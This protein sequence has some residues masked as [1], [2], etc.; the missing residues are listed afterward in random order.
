MR[1]A[2]GQNKYSESDEDRI[3]LDVPPLADKIEEQKGDR[4]VGRG[5][6]NVGDS[7]EPEHRRVPEITHPVR[8]ELGGQQ[9]TKKVGHEQDPSPG[10]H[11]LRRTGMVQLNTSCY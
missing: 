7:I 6:Q 2:A 4:V 5:D 8:H 1:S 3:E 9:L 10:E 11:L